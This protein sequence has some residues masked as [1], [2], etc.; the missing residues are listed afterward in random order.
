MTPRDRL[1]VIESCDG[2]GACCQVVTSPPFYRV[3]NQG[4]EDGW[5]RLK[6][7][8]PDLLAELLADE[9]ARRTSGGPF[10]GTPCTWYDPQSHRCRHYEY[11]PRA[12]REFERGGQDCRD[13]RRR[14]G[15]RDA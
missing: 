12:C 1:S 8:R 5:E 4:G 13:A 11:R 14:A 3:F 6:W 2:C 7:D 15:M 9:Q 10:F